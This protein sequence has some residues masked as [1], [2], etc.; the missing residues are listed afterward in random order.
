VE[1]EVNKLSVT[2]FVELIKAA[3]ET[4]LREMD[5]PWPKEEAELTA[6]VNA[7]TERQHD[8]GTCV[9]AMSMSALAA[10]YYVSH[11]LGVTG[12]QAGCADMD[13]IKRTRGMEGGF[14]ILNYG[15]LLYPQYC[16]RDHFPDHVDLL[17]N[18]DIRKGLREKARERLAEK[19]H[20]HPNV[21]AH[22]ERLVS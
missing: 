17:A 20:A 12:F 6:I 22:W 10:F 1:E 21:K 11:K 13:F 16:N 4:K 2:E 18:P 8:Y 14:R 3:D 19:T 5:V 7:L 9:Y 15:D